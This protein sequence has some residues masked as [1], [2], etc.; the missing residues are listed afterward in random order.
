MPAW[1]LAAFLVA[2]AG[3]L[4]AR[5]DT[6]CDVMPIGLIAER[7]TALDGATGPLGCAI[8]REAGVP[9][10]TARKTAFQ[11]GEVV[12]SPAQGPRMLVAAYQQE[13]NIIVNWGDTAPRDYD[14][15][16]VRWDR[17]GHNVGQSDVDS[18]IDRNQ[19]F[20]RIQAPL[21]GRYTIIVEG[22]NT[23]VGGSHCDQKWTS[24]VTVEYQLPTLPIYVG[25]N[26]A[27][28]PFGL[29]GERWAQTGGAE[30]PL[31]CPVEREHPVQ[32]RSGA[33][34]AFS[35]GMVVFSPDQGAQMTVAAF[36]KDRNLVLDWGDTAPFGYDKF[37]VRWDRNGQNVGQTDTGKGSGGHW[38]TPMAV[39]GAYSIIVEGCQTEI[40]GS[41]CDQ[42]WTIPAIV[43]I[44]ADTN[45]PIQPVGLIRDRWIALGAKSSP[46]GCATAQE[47]AV[48]GRNGRASPFEHGEI[49][50][51]PDQGN[52]M[53]VAAY[54]EG[55]NITLDWGDSSPHN[56]DKFIVR[57]DKDGHN[58]GQEDTGKGRSGH[59]SKGVSDGTYSIIVEG[60][61]TGIGGSD[62]DQKWTIPATVA[63]G[64][65]SPPPPPDTS[66]DVQPVGLIRDRWIAMG[67]KASPL[68]CATE[69]EH[70]IPGR[71]GRASPFEHG[72]IVWSP[73]QGS[74]LTI[75]AYQLFG[76][77]KVE[78]GDTAPFKYDVFLA[79]LDYE[80][81]NVGQIDVKDQPPSSGSVTFNTMRTED[82]ED[83]PILGNGA[84]R[85]SVVIEGCNRNTLS[86]SDCDQKWTVPVS[87]NYRA[88]GSGP[89]VS[90]LA[91]PRTVQEVLAGKSAR[92]L[93]AAATTADGSLDGDWGDDQ[94]PRALAMLYLVSDAASKGQK[95]SDVRRFGQRFNMITEINDGVRRQVIY[96]KSGTSSNVPA[97]CKRTGEYDVAMKGYIPVLYRYGSL[98]APDVRYRIL[99]L[100]NKTGPHNPDDWTICSAIPESENHRWMIESSRYLTNQL[101]KQK[102][103]DPRFENSKNGMDAFI[104]R[105]LMDHL[106][107]DFIEY[108]AR[109]YS[110]YTWAAI[111]N[112]YDYAENPW[113]KH[114]A[115]MVLD[116]L[117]AKAAV[118]SDD[119]RRDPP[120]RRRVS[121]NHTNMYHEQADRL[122]KRFLLYTA[123][124]QTMSELQPPKFVEPFAASEMLLAAASTY[125]PPEIVLDLMVNSAH[126][127]FWQRFGG[128]SGEVYAGEP[129]FLISGGGRP[130]EEAYKVVGMGKDEDLG[131]V[132]PTFLMP[133]GQFTSVSQMIRFDKLATET[134]D[135]SGLCVAPGFACG[136]HPVV[137][138]LYTSN[139]ACVVREQGWTFIDFASDSCKDRAHRSLGFFVAVFGENQNF[140]LFEAVPK[141][142]L[143]GVSLRAFADRTKAANANRSFRDGVVNIY[144]AWG[145][146][147]IR[148]NNSSAQPILATG[149]P[150]IDALLKNHAAG[151]TLGTIVTIGGS[152]LKLTLANP[153]TNTRYV[154]DSAKLQ[155]ETD[156]I[157][158]STGPQGPDAVLQSLA[159]AGVD[160]SVPAADVHDWLGNAEYTSYPAI[161]Q[162]TLNLIGQKRLKQPVYLD[163]IIG[164]YENG[165]GGSSPRKVGD[166]KIE[167]LR[168]AVTRSY[169]E[170]YGQHAS[171]FEE[172]TMPR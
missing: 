48:P 11:H 29:I 63:M 165:A 157:P 38:S 135:A 53:V 141:A 40:G 127:S 44:P 112:I 96:A 5:A 116:Y 57:W 117:S 158:I 86:H 107:S 153:V 20:F 119:G 163:V 71:N 122:K 79:R 55:G 28:Q 150:P 52:A 106:Q 68:G 50:W 37:I 31:G 91:T 14:K 155:A 118:S 167:R 41:D 18:Y 139:P 78:W 76:S 148:F 3:V 98:L 145:G 143:A 103:A 69:P 149:L 59:W 72:E 147:D 97:L 156:T 51:S 54:Q 146:N 36:W 121:H 160:Y 134:G 87:V 6:R 90:A 2:L 34:Q 58:V 144:R 49:V 108:N 125:Q 43:T 33:A 105:M 83:T 172:L 62:C 39:P 109:P 47:H 95:A 151:S 26:P 152:P 114:A 4:P 123:P 100:L 126:R 171:S 136:R 164:F 32:G 140:G 115:Q 170:R 129:D 23:D 138:A 84:G 102:S 128:P 168:D 66:C 8:S 137:P 101:W 67:A 74:G 21:P 64:L 104:T 159:Q 16:I 93:L 45:C 24:P 70:P 120:Y 111:Q 1:F 65:P 92:A 82:D 46:L 162:A 94:L 22:C 131:V 80:G 60:C 27:F 13:D 88:F 161:A 85:Y 124:T 61:D 166:V 133:A 7:W 75:A 113:V 99:H 132:Q 73:D 35:N 15:F 89:D 9:N 142:K 56:Y 77:I 10:S 130:T 110:R 19:G 25:C 81:A 30:G 154:L 169:N 42:K 12:F 17:D